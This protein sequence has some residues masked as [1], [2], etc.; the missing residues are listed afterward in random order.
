MRAHHGLG[1]EISSQIPFTLI[2]FLTKFELPFNPQSKFA[3]LLFEI[4]DRCKLGFL[5][6]ETGIVLL[7]LSVNS[8]ACFNYVWTT[9]NCARL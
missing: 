9:K 3:L 5:F 7:K 2:Y 8:G 6:S 4:F 1:N